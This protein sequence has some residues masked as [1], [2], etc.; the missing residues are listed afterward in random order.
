MNAVIR[1]FR[2]CK[3]ILKQRSFRWIVG[4]WTVFLVLT[5]LRDNFLLPELQ[6]KYS[7]SALLPKWPWYVWVI[8]SLG[9]VVVM[10]FEAALA[11]SSQP[12]D[13]APTV[14]GGDQAGT[15]PKP[16][17]AALPTDAVAVVAL[18]QRP[19]P[20]KP[21]L[22]F[23]RGDIVPIAFR[24]SYSEG[25][26][27]SQSQDTGNIRGIIACFRNDHTSSHP[28]T[29]ASYVRAHVIYRDDNGQEI[30]NGIPSACWFDSHFDTVDF[31]VGQ[32]HCV[33]LGY[34]ERIDRLR[35]PWKERIRH[36]DG[37]T[38]NLSDQR[39]DGVSSIEVKLIDGNDDLLF[40]PL[41]LD[42]SFINDDFEIV[43]RAQ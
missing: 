30:G 36:G 39:F 10:I 23:L 8:V 1:R 27:F 17:T 22:V 13:V 20:R 11:L 28:V 4:A 9:V 41:V 26:I 29:E 34:M 33:F 43:R 7:P 12:Q 40:G 42:I 19:Q 38:I 37:D 6:K 3:T 24:N 25:E 32:S 21:N 2:F 14:S 18:Q 16:A 15:T 31:R 5:K 35:V